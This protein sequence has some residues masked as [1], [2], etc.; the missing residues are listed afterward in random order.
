MMGETVQEL[1]EVPIGEIQAKHLSKSITVK[2]QIVEVGNI[3]PKIKKAIFRCEACET[4]IEIPQST[5]KELLTPQICSNETCGR[6]NCFEL[7]IDESD[8]IDY[9]W[10]RIGKILDNYGSVDTNNSLFVEIE[11]DLVTEPIMD[12]IVSI[13]GEVKTSLKGKTNS[14]TKIGD[15]ILYATAIEKVT[16]NELKPSLKK[17]EIRK[18]N[19]NKV[20]MIEILKEMKDSKNSHR[21]LLE[22]VYTTTQMHDISKIEVDEL[23]VELERRGDICRTGKDLIVIM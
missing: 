10:I 7:L 22:D 17:P 23:M 18:A 9:R 1:I 19:P 11:G 6:S 13:T 21:L 2:G 12:A 4:N 3:Q 5:S 8:I 14:R 16:Q 15:Y 20:K